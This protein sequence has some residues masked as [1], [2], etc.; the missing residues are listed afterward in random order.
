MSLAHFIRMWYSLRS[1][2]IAILV[3]LPFLLNFVE[4]MNIE[5]TRAWYIIYFHQ[6]CSLKLGPLMLTICMPLTLGNISRMTDSLSGV[7]FSKSHKD[8]LMSRY[9]GQIWGETIIFQK[10]TIHR[11][12]VH[13][14]PTEMTKYRL[15]DLTQWGHHLGD[16]ISGAF[17]GMKSFAFRLKVQWTR[18]CHW[19]S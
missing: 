6:W 16:Q 9:A 11:L 7:L 4:I 5:K 8:H 17:S 12:P 10:C 19:F 15:S 14:R 18:S 3:I 1:K 13:R 2:F